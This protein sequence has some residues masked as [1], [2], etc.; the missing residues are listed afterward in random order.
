MRKV[1][2]GHGLFVLVYVEY[3]DKAFKNMHSAQTTKVVSQRFVVRG[4]FTDF[5]YFFGQRVF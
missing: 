5:L 4:I 2:Q 1:N 3:Q